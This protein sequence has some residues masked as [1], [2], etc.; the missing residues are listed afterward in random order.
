VCQC[1]DSTDKCGSNCINRLTFV[2]CGIECG[3]SCQNR[4]IQKKSL[5]SKIEVFDT[6]DKG[7][8]V[9]TTQNIEKGSG[10]VEY[11]GE[12]VSM[13]TYSDRMRRSDT[14]YDGKV[15]GIAV[16]DDKVIDAHLYGNEARFINH[17]CD[18][19]CVAQKWSVGSTT[20][21]IITAAKDIGKGEELTFDY[22]FQPFNKSCMVVRT[23]QAKIYNMNI[24]N[25]EFTVILK[26][27]FYFLGMQVQE[28]Q[29]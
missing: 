2:E 14:L 3:I 18:P 28:C 25:E 12:L 24:S 16:D 6:K 11:L 4:P 13:E 8:G 27:I 26:P 20:R 19:N 21:I 22:D 10:I 15:Y 5:G 23:I 17:S 1:E 29:M 7:Y 9:R